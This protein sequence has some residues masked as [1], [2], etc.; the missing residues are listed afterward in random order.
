M[1]AL[2]NEEILQNDYNSRVNL[3]FWKYD[4]GLN[5]IWWWQIWNMFT[6]IIPI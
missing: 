3:K 6:P 4:F 2:Q 1:N 5:K